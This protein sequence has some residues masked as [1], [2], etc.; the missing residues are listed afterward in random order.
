MEAVNKGAYAGRSLSVGLNIQ[1]PHEQYTNAFQDV[2]QTFRHFFAR[3][4]M[5]AKFACAY[6]VLPGGF[7]TLDELGEVLTLVQTGK[8]RR[9]PIVLV[10]GS[11]WRGLLDW[12]GESL[13]TEGMI[14]PT[15][16]ELI[17][18]IDDPR[19]V[20]DVIFDHYEK[21][22]FA[23]TTAEREAQLNL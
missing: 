6:V 9:I 8:I 13:V 15:D 11:F 3:K 2:S 17:K 21:R 1:L 14:D 5:F 10:Q 18:V 4:V 16:M 22:G 12:I 19:E 23:M 7:G 20:T